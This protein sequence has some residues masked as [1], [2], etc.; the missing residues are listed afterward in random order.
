MGQYHLAA[1][2]FDGLAEMA[3]ASVQQVHECEMGTIT[4]V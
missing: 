2:A 3:P 4:A 1:M